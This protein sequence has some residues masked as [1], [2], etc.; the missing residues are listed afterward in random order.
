MR[1]HPGRAAD[2]LNSL[3][4]EEKR[5][6]EKFKRENNISRVTHKKGN[7][8]VLWEAMGQRYTLRGLGDKAGRMRALQARYASSLVCSC[9]LSGHDRETSNLSKYKDHSCLFM[10]LK[11]SVLG[12]SWGLN[13]SLQRKTKVWRA[14]YYSRNYCH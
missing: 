5:S 10:L 14:K 13:P 1:Q 9:Y 2:A 8:N 4:P 7:E 11:N 6:W 12:V 3:I